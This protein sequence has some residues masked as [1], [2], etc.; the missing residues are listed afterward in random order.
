MKNFEIII[1]KTMDLLK[2]ELI[3]FNKSLDETK[4][5]WIA[6]KKQ[7]EEFIKNDV[8]TGASN[9]ANDLGLDEKEFAFFEVIRKYLEDD[10]NE[11]KLKEEEATYISDE[12]MEIAKDVKAVVKDNYVIDWVI[13]QSKT[14]DIQRAIKLMII[15]KYA[16]RIPRDVREKIMEPLLNLA[17]IHFDVLN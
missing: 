17:K 16:K 4:N 1:A 11:F 15:K 7:L 9:K 3:K 5:D 8:E 12:T 10:A 6:R 14:N 13:N 2:E